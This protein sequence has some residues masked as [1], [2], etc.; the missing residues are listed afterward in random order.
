MNHSPMRRAGGRTSRFSPIANNQTKGK[1][2]GPIRTTVFHPSQK[3]KTG[4][5][6]PPEKDV[7]R[8]V[9][10]GGLEEIGRNCYFYEYKDEIIVVDV[11]IQFPEEETPGIDYIIPNEA[12]LASKK[13]NIKAILLTHGH[14]DHIAAIHYLIEK[15]GN[16]LIYTADFT[17]AVVE[18][19][20]EEFTS[21]PK[22]HFEVVKHGSKTR[23]GKYFNV[24]FFNVDHTVPDALGFVLDTPVGNMVS[25][26]DFRVRMD[27]NGKPTDLEVFED[28]GKRGVRAVFIDS[29]NAL[30]PGFSFSEEAVSDNLEELMSPAK[31]RIVI[32]TFAS[33]MTRLTEIMKIA[34]KL[35]RK[36]SLNG[37][38]MKD[39]FQI[40]QNLGYYKPPKDFLV[41]LEELHKHRDD[42]MVILTTGSQGEPNS[43]LTRIVN[44]EH[45]LM[46]L[47]RTDTVIFSSS[48]VPGNE[49]SV[50]SLQANIARQV[51]EVYNTKILDLHATG[52]AHQEDLK[53]VLRLV[54]PEYVIPIHGYYL[55]RCALRKIAEQVGI[56]KNHVIVMDNGEVA[57]VTKENFTVS[58]EKVPAGYVMVDGL[59]VGD[60][61][62]VVL[63]DRL[64]LSQEGMIVVIVVVDQGGRIV[65]NPDIISRGFIYLK[66][67]QEMLEE[68]RKR[69]KN[70]I[71]RI[72][73][74]REVEPDYVKTLI[75][76]QVGNFLYNK[77]KRRPMILPV[78]I[79]I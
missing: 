32:A 18:R 45:R 72:P 5:E 17:K 3:T 33:L 13:N 61:E 65:K 37:R 16:P 75:R 76:D 55:F 41:P 19:R 35:G 57:Y 77:T 68:V 1:S 20:H 73:N 11:G 69:V 62:E 46:Q 74:N 66:D 47:K 54:K 50:Q 26:G 31:G 9:P 63:R 49:R 7:L 4:G 28:V 38:S 8:F 59:G 15:W 43:G 79:K 22:L 67:N 24:E 53:L 71:G 56:P 10:L 60:V 42:K 6:H 64:N 58:G 27:K 21:A 29:T 2:R 34:V 12:Y 44:G 78:L 51:D 36:V 48:V 23:L 40:M 39:N 14:Y 30:R 52:H 25:F 70:I